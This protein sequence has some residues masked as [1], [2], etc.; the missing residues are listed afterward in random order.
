MIYFRKNT[1][2]GYTPEEIE[3]GI[4][5]F[6]FR[7][8]IRLDFHSSVSYMTGDKYFYGVETSKDIQLTRIR[9]PFERFLPKLIF[10][11]S[12]KDEFIV[13]RVRY[14]YSSLIGLFFLLSAAVFN[15]IYA[16]NTSWIDAGSLIVAGLMAIFLALTVL[17][18]EITRL[19]ILKAILKSKIDHTTSSSLISRQ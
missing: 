8:H 14:A 5:K 7:R 3:R 19:R 18:S 6:S 11:F 10:S 12:K 15:L 17:E 9:T 1:I 2:T 16:F 13:Y 4:R